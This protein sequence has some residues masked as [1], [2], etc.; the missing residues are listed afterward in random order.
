MVAR[1]HNALNDHGKCVLTLDLISI[2]LPNEMLGNPKAKGE[3]LIFSNA[4][5]TPCLP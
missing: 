2:E 4:G 1:S 3:A 5:L